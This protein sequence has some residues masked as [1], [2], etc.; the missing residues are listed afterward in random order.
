[1][2]LG[3]HFGDSFD[4]E[5][6]EDLVKEAS[7]RDKT[8]MLS[9]KLS[10]FE[11]MKS[12][13]EQRLEQLA[14]YMKNETG[15]ISAT[16][17]EAFASGMASRHIPLEVRRQYYPVYFSLLPQTFKSNTNMYIRKVLNCLTPAK[18]MKAY[19]S[20]QMK[21]VFDGLG[22]DDVYIKDLINKLNVL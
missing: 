7:Q 18:D 17:V 14:K 1:M 22:D 13:P 15:S 11:V 12:A 5:L 19:V 6:Y 2:Y 8:D 10:I 4:S 9:Y 21:Q 16:Q 20:A 3:L